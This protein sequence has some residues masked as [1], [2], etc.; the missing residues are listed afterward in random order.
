M[1]RA[2]HDADRL[3]PDGLG[4]LGAEQFVR[5]IADLAPIERYECHWFVEPVQ[6]KAVG[7]E[8]VDDLLHRRDPT[9]HAGMAE[10]RRDFELE[11]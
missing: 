2:E 1:E 11:G 7:E 6:Y 4:D 5:A 10:G 3:G 8:R 9:G